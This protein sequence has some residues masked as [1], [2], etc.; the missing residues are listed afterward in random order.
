MFEL[1]SL[2]VEVSLTGAALF[3]INQAFELARNINGLFKK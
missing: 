3:L 2:F 1:T